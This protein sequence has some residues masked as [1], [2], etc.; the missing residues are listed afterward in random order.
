[1]TS[2]ADAE[3]MTYLTSDGRLVPQPLII[4]E[5]PYNEE[6]KNANCILE[7]GCGVGRNVPWIMENTDAVY[8][9]LDPNQSMLDHFWANRNKQWE[10]R[11]SITSSWPVDN[12]LIPKIDVVLCVFVF[13]HL[14]YEKC[15]EL[16]MNPTDIAN[17][18]RLHTHDDTIWFMLENGKRENGWQKRWFEETGFQPEVYIPGWENKS[19]YPELGHRGGHNL[20]IFKEGNDAV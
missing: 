4:K 19:D 18:I 8:F 7:I 20:I 3:K 9:G 16:T 13:Q 12:K 17:H 1:M 10:Y 11:I 14:S 6:I 15:P 5:N 2:Q